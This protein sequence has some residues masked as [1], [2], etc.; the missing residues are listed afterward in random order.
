M[1][2]K[3]KL[4]AGNLDTKLLGGGKIAWVQGNVGLPAGKGKHVPMELGAV[5][6]LDGSE[7][8]WASLDFMARRNL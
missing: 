4:T 5:L 3:L 8:R 1:K 6:V 7:W 2:A